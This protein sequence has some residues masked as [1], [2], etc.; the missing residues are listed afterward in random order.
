MAWIWYAFT[1]PEAAMTRF[2]RAFRWIVPAAFG[3]LAATVV[4]AGVVAPYSNDFTSASSTNGYLLSGSWLVDTGSV[5]VGS[6]TFN[7]VFSHTTAQAQAFV[8]SFAVTNLG[9]SPLGA[10]DFSISGNL[11]VTNGNGTASYLGLAAL[12]SSANLSTNLYYI[13]HYFATTGGAGPEFRLMRVFAGVT[14]TLASAGSGNR[15]V[16]DLFNK[17]FNYFLGGSYSNGSLVL[18]A[19]YSN[20]TDGVLLGSLS[21]VDSSPLTGNY[22]GIKDNNANSGVPMTVYWNSL[23]VIPEPSSLGMLLLGAAPVYLLARR[24]S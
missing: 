22:F 15:E 21:A 13:Q 1:I 4:R 23:T 10:L 2:S 24:R 11:A 6:A 14:S 3:V 20:L 17:N 12:S 9:G 5:T 18:T 7:G 8:A 19:T 16:R